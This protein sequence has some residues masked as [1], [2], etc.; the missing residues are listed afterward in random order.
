[1]RVRRKIAVTKEMER[2]LLRYLGSKNDPLDT[3][4]QVFNYDSPSPQCLMEALVV[5]EC[6][7][8]LAGCYDREE[9]DGRQ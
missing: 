4:E 2:A 8:R 3:A 9:D 5:A 6:A 7:A 1:M